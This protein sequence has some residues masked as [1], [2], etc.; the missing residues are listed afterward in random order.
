MVH[1]P[2]ELGRSRVAIR[3]VR[4][5]LDDEQ[6]RHVVGACGGADAGQIVEESAA[7]AVGEKGIVVDAEQRRPHGVEEPVDIVAIGRGAERVSRR[8]IGQEIDIG[9][10]L[11]VDGLQPRHHPGELGKLRGIGL[12]DEKIAAQ[13]GRIA[14][15]GHRGGE[16][17]SPSR[18]GEVVQ[19]EARVG[20]PQREPVPRRD[21]QRAADRARR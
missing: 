1:L 15:V 3:A 13:R 5:R 19:L 6:E 8:E 12:V 7:V 4:H 9:D 2:G 11:R 21:L 10:A 20:D 17:A 16:A 14:V 18:R